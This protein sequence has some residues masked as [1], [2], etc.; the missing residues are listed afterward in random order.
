[1]GLKTMKRYIYY[2]ALLITVFT[3]FSCKPG[4][5][6]KIIRKKIGDYFIEAAY[7]KDSQIDGIARYYDVKNSAICFLSAHFGIK[8]NRFLSLS[9]IYFQAIFQD[10]FVLRIEFS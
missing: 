5:K 10:F 1:M 4:A 7:I 8:L 2:T 6:A 3:L 9:I